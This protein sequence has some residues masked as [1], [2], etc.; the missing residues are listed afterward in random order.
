MMLSA[1]DLNVFLELCQSKN[2]TRASEKLGLSQPALSHALKRLEEKLGT[3]LFERSKNGLR[4]TRPGE[5]LE[6]KG[7]ALLAEWDSVHH[8]VREEENQ[9]SGVY[10]I[11]C[12][13][14]VAIYSLPHFLPDLLR[15]FPLIDL[16]LVHGLSRTIA[17]QVI[18]HKLDLGIV[19]NPPRHPDL[20]IKELCQDEV[21]V[22][23]SKKKERSPVIICDPNLLQTQWVLRQLEKVGLRFSRT[24]HSSNLEVISHLVASGCGAGILPTRVVRTVVPDTLVLA[25]PKAPRFTDKICLIYRPELKKNLGGRSLIERVQ[26]AEL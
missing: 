25:H 20:V 2:L 24:I 19:V 6:H 9:V 11:G 15:D 12:H 5:R 7:R 26:S 18:S 8:Y 14:S 1:H 4:L 22:W 17:E 3:A 13:P 23:V 10:K 16:R 21:S